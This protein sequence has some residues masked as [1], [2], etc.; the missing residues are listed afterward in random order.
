MSDQQSTRCLFCERS[1][2]ETLLIPLVYH[3]ERIGI[4][5]QHLPI[6][7]HDP[8]QLV[9]VEPRNFV[10]LNTTTDTLARLCPE[11]LMCLLT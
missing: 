6:L 4:C 7:I 8:G 9:G 5:P 11:G 10:R 1:S 2:D 3:S